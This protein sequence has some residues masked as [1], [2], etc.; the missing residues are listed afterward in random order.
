LAGAAADEALAGRAALVIL[1][2]IFWRNTWKYQARAFRHLFWDSGTLLANL[3]AAGGAMGLA[4]AL[5]TGFVDDAV[6]HVLGLDADREAALEIVALG[7]AGA[8]GAPAG[9]L[10]G[11]ALETMPLSSREVDYPLLREMMAASRLGS[12]DEVRAWRGDEAGPW[13]GAQDKRSPQHRPSGGVVSLPSPRAVSGSALSETIQ[14]RGSTRQF[15]HAPLAQ[16]SLATTLWA[17]TRP[18]ASDVPS[19]LVDLF[20]IVNAVDG[21][22]PGAYRYRADSHALETVR[23]EARR[24]RAAYLCLEQPLAGDAAVVIFFLTPLDAVL[25]RWGNRG[26]RLVNLEAGIAGGRA[27]LAAYALGFGAS[28]L[29]FYD[30]LVV[31]AFA[32]AS[33]GMDA[34][35]VTALGHSARAER[36]PLVDRISRPAR[37]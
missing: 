18:V 20:L 29:T 27:Y 5:I 31:D 35:F 19:D 9:P 33:A 7:P 8:P 34:I 30:R 25:A 16:E 11:L 12:A 14:R 6:N 15:S 26:Y 4:P 10:P 28:G 17:A 24:D 1:T 13:R 23:H 2:G 36:S 21:V 37:D 3:L 22:E 32:P